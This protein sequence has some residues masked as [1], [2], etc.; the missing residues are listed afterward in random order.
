MAAAEK[1]LGRKVECEVNVEKMVKIRPQLKSRWKHSS[2]KWKAISSHEAT[3]KPI[4]PTF[5][6]ATINKQSNAN[7]PIEE[8]QQQIAKRA[9]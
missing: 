2:E 5:R 1:P 7:K 9:V 3:S 4:Y 6:L 8:Q